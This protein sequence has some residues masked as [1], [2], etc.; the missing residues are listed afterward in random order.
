MSKTLKEFMLRQTTGQ[1]DL[2]FDDD[3][4]LSY[5]M[6]DVVTAQTDPVTGGIGIL[7]GGKYRGFGKRAAHRLVTLGDSICIAGDTIN[8]TYDQ[9]YDSFGDSAAALSGGRV[10]FVRNAG[11][12]GDKSSDLI[13][14]FDADVKPWAPTVVAMIVGT[15]DFTNG[16]SDAA[17]RANIKT[18]DQKCRAIGAVPVFLT[19]PPVNS[20]SAEDALRI[21]RNGAWLRRWGMQNDVL[22]I[23]AFGLSVD[24]ASAGT[25][26]SG[27]DIGDGIHPN[28]AMHQTWGNAIATIFN[29]LLPAIPTQSFFNQDPLN[30]VSNGLFQNGTTIATGYNQTWGPDAGSAAFSVI[31][32]SAMPGGKAQRHTLTSATGHASLSQTVSTGF[33]PG[34]ALSIEC[35]TNLACAGGYSHIEATFTGSTGLTVVS[36]RRSLQGR[37]KFYREFV[38]PPGT[39]EIKFTMS[40]GYRSSAVSGTV[41]FGG[42]TVRNLSSPAGA[43]GNDGGSILTPDF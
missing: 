31:A 4:T 9:R 6:K 8:A 42:L 37:S 3:S 26:K 33:S 32:D 35:D 40:S 34:D 25:W 21:F 11:H 28:A 15:N 2:E 43:Y 30:L 23:D 14:R 27:S 1:V 18:L 16:V 19:S 29:Q 24:P 36:S 38:V 22:V 10:Q 12:G 17:Y 39:T 20:F 7:V 5:N 13:A 41:D